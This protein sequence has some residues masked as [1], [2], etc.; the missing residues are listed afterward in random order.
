VPALLCQRAVV[1]GIDGSPQRC[2]D[3]SAA[4]VANFVARRLDQGLSGY[5]A[6]ASNTWPT[7]CCR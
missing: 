5:L 7:V 4:R 1:Q 2:S 3:L 6:T